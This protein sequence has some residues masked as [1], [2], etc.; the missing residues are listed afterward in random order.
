MTSGNHL[1]TLTPAKEFSY[2]GKIN[3]KSKLCAMT[4]GNHLLT[5]TPAEEFL[6]LAVDLFWKHCYKMRNC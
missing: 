3:M 1:F 4:S 5:M 2:L 6:Y